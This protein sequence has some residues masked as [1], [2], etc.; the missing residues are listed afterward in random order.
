M[1]VTTES[2]TELFPPDEAAIPEAWRRPEPLHQRQYL[3]DGELREWH[4]PTQVVFSPIQLRDSDGDLT[5]I[6]IGSYP[7]LDEAESLKALDAA[8]RA[9]DHGRGEWPTMSVAERIAAVEKFTR[10]IVAQKKEI[11]QLLLWEIGKSAADSEKEF[12]RTVDYIRNTI[13]ALKDIDRDS[14]RFTIEEGIIGQIRRSPLGV[15]LCMGPFNYPLNETFCMLIPA[16]IMGNTVLFKPPKH[17]ALLHFPLLKAFTEAFPKGVVNT[18]YGRGN[19]IVPALM[20]S[21]K[22]DVLGLI[23]SS[24]VADSL[25][26]LHPKS[27]RLRAILGLD[28]KNVAIIMADADLDVAV[29]ES[30]LG[31]LS[32]NGQRCTA[33][34]LFFVHES[35]A[36]EFVRRM[37]EEI[38]KLKPGMPWDE[39]VNIT[40]L[41]EPQKPG[42]LGECLEDAQAKG[43]RIMNE[44]GG[45]CAGPLV[46]PA[47]VYPVKDGM[48]L[49]REEQFGPVVPVASFAHVDEAIQ[50]IIDSDHGQQVSIFSSES[51]EVANLVDQLVNQVSRVNI[52][53]QCQRGPDTFPFTGRKDSA[54]GTLSVH[55]ALRSFSIRTVVA[56]KQTDANKHILNDIVNEQESN[57]LS[58]RFIL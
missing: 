33:L 6:V 51:Q 4:G 12:D 41:P 11:V 57:F 44:G 49:W 45:M 3:L 2:L 13:D 1:P 56:T 40:P 24:R 7:L 30:V 14:S 58:T 32:F 43:A 8:V 38:N 20:S 34:K 10:L 31:A 26:K 54:E 55:D 27:N 48:K 52:N 28:A 37:A 25:K 42:Y 15:V 19:T 50:Y 36:E 29:K 22:I 46:Y 53:A 18:V 5:P 9:Y 23:G 47:L 21:G 16:L 35:I 17:G 39:K